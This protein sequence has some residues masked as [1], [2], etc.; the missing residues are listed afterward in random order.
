MCTMPQNKYIHILQGGWGGGNSP[1]KPKNAKKWRL[2]I[3]LQQILHTGRKDIS[4]NDV[5]SDSC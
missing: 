1:Q 2:Y 3:F 4:C 5:D